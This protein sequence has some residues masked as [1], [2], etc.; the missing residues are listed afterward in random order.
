MTTHD[1]SESSEV[2]A[3]M[4]Q[5]IEI[6]SDS[7]LLQKAN[8]RPRVNI[9][10][11]SQSLEHLTGAYG[12]TGMSVLSKGEFVVV[13]ADRLRMPDRTSQWAARPG[14]VKVYRGNQPTYY[15]QPFLGLYVPADG[16]KIKI[17]YSTNAVLPKEQLPLVMR[18]VDGV[19]VDSV[20][21][22]FVHRGK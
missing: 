5:V 15:G 4:A 19:F 10:A 11:E 2:L 13:V 16:H 3:C 17:P 9:V 18:R 1:S 22:K 21:N 14:T 12:L 6:K 7:V 8:T 20:N